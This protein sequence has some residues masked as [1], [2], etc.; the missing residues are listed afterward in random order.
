MCMIELQQPK[1]L[2][3]I[4]EILELEL[5]YLDEM[6]ERVAVAIALR[7]WETTREDRAEL[8][9]QIT[10]RLAR[11][12]NHH[13]NYDNLLYS[14]LSAIHQLPAACVETM[15]E[16]MKRAT[17]KTAKCMLVHL[18]ADVMLTYADAIEMYRRTSARQIGARS[19]A[20]WTTGT[21]SDA[22]FA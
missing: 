6:A 18:C 7:S 8:L 22:Y 20:Q 14:T 2:C 4:S 11:I 21:V 5:L 19:D 12:T 15:R 9:E 3:L 17:S 1:F 13:Y 16:L 10:E